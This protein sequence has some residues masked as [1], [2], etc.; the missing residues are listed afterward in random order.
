MDI[1]IAV[2]TF[3]SL[4]RRLVDEWPSDARIFP[5]EYIDAIRGVSFT[6]KT[7]SAAS[8]SRRISNLDISIISIVLCT[9]YR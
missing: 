4:C 7:A 5:S 6:S 3:G 9:R 8:L 2:P 1:F